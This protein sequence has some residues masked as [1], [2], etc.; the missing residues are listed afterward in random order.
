MI[1]VDVVK[2]EEIKLDEKG[3][4]KQKKEPKTPRRSNSAKPIAA[5]PTPKRQSKR[6][7]GDQQPIQAVPQPTRVSTR[8]SMRLTPSVKQSQLPPPPPLPKQSKVEIEKKPNKEEI[9]NQIESTSEEIKPVLKNDNENE[10]EQEIKIEQERTTPSVCQQLKEDLTPKIEDVSN[11]K[12]EQKVI[13]KEEEIEEKIK[14]Q[15]EEKKDE[16]DKEVCLVETNQNKSSHAPLQQASFDID[17]QKKTQQQPTVQEK[18]VYL[19]E[20]KYWSCICLNLDDWQSVHD[21]YSI[22]KKK[23]DQD[24]AKLLAESY[25]PEMPTLFQKAVIKYFFIIISL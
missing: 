7:T 16:D 22:S 1:L 9:T 5:T 18:E 17:E 14:I 10:K 25:L 6:L 24:I 8:R 3:E 13:L 23:S 20:L 4:N 21:K 2:Q 12:E 15:K 11:E 19:K